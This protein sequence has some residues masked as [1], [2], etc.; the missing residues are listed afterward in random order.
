VKDL[1]VAQG[2]IFAA[3]LT[4][5]AEIVIELAFRRQ[6]SHGSHEN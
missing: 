1:T 5:G 3:G 4:C 2:G 6:H